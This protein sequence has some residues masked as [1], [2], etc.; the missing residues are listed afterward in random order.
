MAIR[1]FCEFCRLTGFWIRPSEVVAAIRAF[2]IGFLAL[3]EGMVVEGGS[4]CKGAKS[5][6]RW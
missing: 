6:G 1:L 3:T 4:G 5:G 2:L